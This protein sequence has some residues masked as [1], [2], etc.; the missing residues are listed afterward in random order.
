MTSINIQ[1]IHTLYEDRGFAPSDQ[2]DPE[3]SNITLKQLKQIVSMPLWWT[4]KTLHE[5]LTEKYPDSCCFHHFL[6][7]E[8]KHGEFKVPHPGL[9]KCFRDWDTYRAN[10]VWKFGGM[11][12]TTSGEFY[13]PHRA[14]SSQNVSVR[15]SKIGIVVGPRMK[16]ASDMLDDIR[17]KFRRKQGIE[18]EGNRTQIQFPP[19]NRVELEVFPSNVHISSIRGQK[20]M[21]ILWFDECDHVS[22]P[23]ITDML[24]ALQRY[25]LKSRCQLILVSTPKAPDHM[26]DIIQRKYAHL[27]HIEKY[28]V[29]D[30][31]IPWCYTEAEVEEFK[32]WSSFPREFMCE[33]QGQIGNVFDPA[34]IDRAYKLG[35]DHCRLDPRMEPFYPDRIDDPI[36]ED[37]AIIQYLDRSYNMPIYP[38]GIGSD[39]GHGSSD[40]ATVITA[41]R[42]NFIDVIYAKKFR[43]S[44]PSGMTKLTKTLATYYRSNKIHVDGN[45]AGA[46]TDLKIEFHENNKENKYDNL[47]KWR[48][49]AIQRFKVVP[50]NFR[51][52]HKMLLQTLVY[53][54]DK[55]KIR[56]HPI[57]KDLKVAL[58]TATA[59]EFDLDKEETTY[60][61]LLD[62]FML[63][64]LTHDLGVRRVSG[65]NTGGTGINV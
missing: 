34:W 37:E 6:G 46:I 2:V 8:E 65:S 14:I 31:G 45:N 23:Q 26:L 38:K 19:P 12:V 20:N 7:L 27:Y 36:L 39:P 1:K 50:V 40:H 15:N 51:A 3:N 33:L 21:S 43:R 47:T 44:S 57:F 55:G 42:D 22:K 48:D 5:K 24:D 54:M 18:F 41:V 35:L 28:T 16:L 49:P 17:D 64:I 29:L 25:L 56:I 52:M 30:W 11:A 13:L 32:K 58:Q 53:L 62:A 60:D 4:D 63:S 59:T 9:I 61:D 10:V